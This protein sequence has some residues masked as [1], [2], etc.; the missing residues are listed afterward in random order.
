MKR[1]KVV[2]S[3]QARDDLQR[4]YDYIRFAAGAETANSY[5]G[6]LEAYVLGFETASERG[7]RRD[8]VRPGLR[9]VG[10]ER[11]LTIAFSIDAENV[12]I[13]RLFYAGRDWESAF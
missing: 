3:P 1:R 6:R 9:T 11:R 13:L 4:L 10:F 12:T 2:F 8:D 7:Q 5:I